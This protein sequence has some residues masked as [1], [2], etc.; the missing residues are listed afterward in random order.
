MDRGCLEVDGQA[1][2]LPDRGETSEF[3]NHVRKFKAPYVIYSDFECLT[4]RTGCYSK[5]MLPGVMDEKASTLNCQKHIPTG[6][7][8]IVVYDKRKILRTDIYRGD[9]CMDK[10]SGFRQ[11]L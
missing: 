4:S 6:L 7:K 2:K 11:T 1:V 10:F 8:L 3:R 9:D 5:P